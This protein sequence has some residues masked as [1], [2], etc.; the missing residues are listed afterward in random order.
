MAKPK[1]NKK[2][3]P[4]TSELSSFQ[5]NT[6]NREEALTTFI[7]E[8]QK[9]NIEIQTSRKAALNALEEAILSKEA[10]RKSEEKYRSLFNSIDEGFCIIEILFDKYDNAYDYRFLET[11]PEF[12]NQ[13]GLNDSIGKTILELVPQHEKFWFEV[14]GEIAV[15]GKARRF[16]HKA[17]ALVPPRWFDVYAFRIGAPGER[18]VAV[19]F[20]DIAER[21]QREQ[22]QQ[23]L[24]KFSDALRAEPHAD[25]IANR[26]IKMVAEHLQLD[27]CYV[28]IALLND[29]RGIFPYQFGNERVPPMPEA[30]SLSDFPEAL[31]RTFDE[32]LVITDFQSMEGLTETEKQNFAAL[33]FGALVVANVR[34]AEKNPDWSINAVSAVPRH[35]TA[36]EIQLIEEVTE[37]TWAAIERAKG[38]EALAESEE[39]FRFALSSADMAAWDWNTSTDIVTWNEQ[40]FY[41]LGL[42]PDDKERK[43]ADFLQYVYEDDHEKVTK[44]LQEAVNSTGIYREDFRIVRN[45]GAIRWMSGYGRVV[46]SKDGIVTRMAGVMYDITER[47]KTEEKVRES[48]EQLQTLFNYAPMGMYLV[49]ARFIISAVNTKAKSVFGEASAQVGKNFDKVMHE[50]W[51]QEYADEI[52]GIV[53]HTLETGELYSIPERIEYRR[54]VNTIEYYEWQVHRIAMPGGEYGVVCYFKDVSSFVFARKAIAKSEEKYRSLFEKMEEGLLVGELVYNPE[55][56]AEDWRYLE[57]NPALERMIELK[58]EQV[59]GKTRSEAFGSVDPY[60]LDIYSEVVATSNTTRLEYFV[61]TS[62]RWFDI[63]VYASGLNRFVV[64]YDDI[65]DRKK[66]E[67]ALRVLSEEKINAQKLEI[68]ANQELIRKKDEFISIASHELRTPLTPIM[69]CIDMLIEKYKENNDEFLSSS[70]STLNRQVGKL[71]NLFNNLLDISRADMHQLT[72]NM[73]DF[74]IAEMVYETI[75][76]MQ[77]ATT[78]KLVANGVKHCNVYGDRIRLNQVFL[79]LLTNAIK[80]SPDAKE[81]DIDILCSKAAVTIA[82]KD[83]GIGIPDEYIDKIF[84]RFYRVEEQVANTFGGFGIGL[85]IA[86]E[87]IRYH[88]GSITVKSEKGKGSVFYLTLPLMFEQRKKEK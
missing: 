16:E 2:S 53:K 48:E 82:V 52:V 73:Q 74:D 66:A 70:L 67:E 18:K 49:N 13:T 35:W 24:I 38:E 32:T 27:R 11:N 84:E 37:R 42:Q 36:L 25:A 81:V 78:H 59:F 26:A 87:I 72:Y 88:N 4:I 5:K 23:F 85:Y 64:L 33:G 76:M 45:D 50:L 28:G 31:R 43:A 75:E 65:T 12:I 69:I 86:A 1:S 6:G 56:E 10:L 79:N 55:G 7:E 58:P 63:T 22:Q 83:F 34:K 3:I 47:K 62:N 8:L 44:A 60:W 77:P 51:G 71:S 57:L 29:N 41:I 14:F 61:P 21:K 39:R 20:K 17:R 46:A 30:V 54:D 15:N 9:A 80:Y 19:L 68:S 40:H